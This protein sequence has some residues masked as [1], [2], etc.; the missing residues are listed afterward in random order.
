MF[1]LHAA[2]IRIDENTGE[3][4][5][6][7]LTEGID[8]TAIVQHM[9]DNSSDGQERT[10][11]LAKLYK[12]HATAPNRIPAVIATAHY[13]LFHAGQ[14]ADGKTI[15]HPSLYGIQWFS[16]GEDIPQKNSR[17]YQSN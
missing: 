6:D 1:G 9:K 12:E 15:S 16:N 10:E 7:T 2:G 4:S 3:F 13:G 17:C 8:K 5:P 11:I 14:D